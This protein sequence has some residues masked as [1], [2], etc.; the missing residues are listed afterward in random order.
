MAAQNF[1]NHKRYHPFYHYFILPLSFTTCVLGGIHLVKSDA[2]NHYNAAL[3]FLALFLI[4]CVAALT[5]VYALKVQN[6]II[7]SEENFRHFVLT[8]KPLDSTLRMGQ[9]I[10]LRF[11]SD[12][13]LPALAQKA[14][15]EKLSPAA[16]KQSITRWRGD[17][18]R[19]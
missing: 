9:I 6:R 12:E 4:L 16:I 3:I 8:G 18:H 11:A 5:R 14:L 13:E 15:S 7:R 10:A 2:H 1:S 19:I 17:Y